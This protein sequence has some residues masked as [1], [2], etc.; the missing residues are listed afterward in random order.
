MRVRDEMRINKSRGIWARCLKKARGKNPTHQ[1]MKEETPIRSWIFLFFSLSFSLFFRKKIFKKVEENKTKQT[2][3]CSGKWFPLCV[4]APTCL[5]YLNVLHKFLFSL[6]SAVFFSPAW[7]VM[8]HM[9]VC[10]FKRFVVCLH[11]CSLFLNSTRVALKSEDFL[12]S[13][14]F[15][16]PDVTELRL[17]RVHADCAAN[18]WKGSGRQIRSI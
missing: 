6:S 11:A 8:S 3:E 2:R 1:A 16:F 17:E 10:F 7:T 9:S 15:L 18:C 13:L 5:I 12:S 14:F 4:N